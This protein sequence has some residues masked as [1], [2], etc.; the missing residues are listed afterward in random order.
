MI[1][2]EWEDLQWTISPRDIFTR[3]YHYFQFNLDEIYFLCN[4]GELN[5]IGSKDKPAMAKIS[6]TKGFQ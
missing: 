3:F 4:K 5:V 1:E 6:A 2:V